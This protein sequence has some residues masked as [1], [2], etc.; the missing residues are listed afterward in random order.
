[1][2]HL[3]QKATKNLVVS[4]LSGNMANVTAG[5]QEN[6][7]LTDKKKKNIYIYAP[8]ITNK[9]TEFLLSG[10]ECINGDE[11]N[12][13]KVNDPPGSGN[14]PFFLLK[15]ARHQKA[16]MFYKSFNY[17]NFITFNLTP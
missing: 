6:F 1:M 16:S 14:T 15:T 17:V 8:F 7:R 13:P 5:V 4:K 2:S 12:K 11:L 9:S 3:L 10:C